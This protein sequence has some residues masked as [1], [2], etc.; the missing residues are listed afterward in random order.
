MGWQE[1]TRSKIAE[2]IFYEG[3]K[4]NQRDYPYIKGEDIERH[5]VLPKARRWLR[6][7]YDE[8]ASK[9]ETVSV[10]HEWAQKTPKIVSRQTADEII[11]AADEDCFYTGRSVHTTVLLDKHYNVFFLTALLN[12]KLLTYFYRGF[13]QEEGRAQAQVILDDV[14]RL[15]IPVLD[16]KRKQDEHKHDELAQLGR[17][18]REQVAKEACAE[19][20]FSEALNSHPHEWR[21]LG[22][23][24]WNRPEYVKLI[25]KKSHVKPTD[26]GAIT[27]FRCEMDDE[28]IQISA[29]VADDWKPVLDM[30]VADQKLRLFI[31][32][33]I[34]QFLRDNSRKR[35]WGEGKLLALTLDAIQVPVFLSHGVHDVETQLGTLKLVLAEMK[36]HSPLLNP[37]ELERDIAATDQEIDRRVYDLYGLT[38]AER[39]L[40][41]AS[42]AHPARKDS[43]A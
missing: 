25:E 34:R 32:Y 43:A 8:F 33:G 40:V 21:E 19:A 42:F 20:A 41:E 28:T 18:I 7:N 30:T 3:A 31:L 24:Y 29:R 39:A 17:N 36:K 12:S 38:A 9:N 2:A 15:P 6:R 5:K 37:T 27:G 11:C 35:K 13:S 1:R 10:N 26:A 22:D 23:T 16:F 14:R 4:Q